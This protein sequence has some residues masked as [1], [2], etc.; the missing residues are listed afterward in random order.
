MLKRIDDPPETTYHNHIQVPKY[1]LQSLN[2]EDIQKEIEYLL[3]VDHEHESAGLE[4]IRPLIKHLATLTVQ[5]ADRAIEEFQQDMTYRI[6][7][8]LK[9]S[10]TSII[11][12][13][14]LPTTENAIVSTT[15]N[16]KGVT[17]VE[18]EAFRDW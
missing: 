3:F 18:V 15:V 10:V 1:N 16:D 8:E 2:E 5:V 17:K 11:M 6:A 13:S 12:D 14:R 9:D 7:K 4:T